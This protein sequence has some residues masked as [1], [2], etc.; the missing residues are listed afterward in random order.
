MASFGNIFGSL[1]GWLLPDRPKVKAQKIEEF[2][3]PTAEDGREFGRGYGTFWV[4]GPNVT[5]YGDLLPRTQTKNG[6][7]MIRYYMGLHIDWAEGPWDA[8]LE[9]R[10]NDP[11]GK[12]IWSGSVTSSQQITLT[13]DKL[14][15][16]RQKGGGVAGPLDVMMGED[17]QIANDYL[18]GLLGPL[19]AF[20]GVVGT[21]FRRGL[22]GANAASVT[23]WVAKGRRI[24]KGWYNDDCWYPERADAFDPFNLSNVYQDLADTL[25][26]DYRWILDSGFITISDTEPNV[27]VAGTMLLTA[28]FGSGTTSAGPPQLV[29]NCDVHIDSLI[30]SSGKTRVLTAPIS[31]NGTA[32]FSMGLWFR[33]SALTG[34]GRLFSSNH[35][36]SSIGDR[37]R[38]VNVSYQSTGAIWIMFGDGSGNEDYLATYYYATDTGVV[39]Y[40]TITQVVLTCGVGS[41]PATI[42]VHLYVNG[43]EKTLTPIIT[44]AVS[45]G[46]LVS[47]DYGIA[48]NAWYQVELGNGYIDAEAQAFFTFGQLTSGNVADLYEAGAAIIGVPMNDMNPAHILYDL[49]THPYAG[50][51]WPAAQMDDANYRA[52]ADA[53]YNEGFGLSFPPAAA[54]RRRERIAEIEEHV[55]CVCRMSSTGKFQVVLIRYDYNPD[56]LITWTDANIKAIEDVESVGYGELVGRIA[57]SYTD[58]DTGITATTAFVTNPTTIRAQAGIANPIVISYPGIRNADLAARVRDRELRKRSQPLKAFTVLLDRSDVTVE[59]GDVRKINST[60]YGYSGVIVRVIAVNRGRLT[61]RMMQIKV[62]EDVGGLPDSAYTTPVVSTWVE[63]ETAPIAIV[64]QDALEIPYHWMRAA[65]GDAEALSV[66]DTEGFGRPLAVT[67]QALAIGYDLWGRISPADYV[68][69]ADDLEFFD[70]ATLSA[71]IARNDTTLNITGANIDEDVVGPGHL[72]IVGDATTGEWMRITGGDLS[73]TITVDR[74]ILDTTPQEHD[75]GARVWVMHPEFNIFDE[76]RYVDADVVDYKMLTL[77]NEDALAI[78]DATAVSVTMDSRQ[79]RPYP[80]AGMTINGEGYPTSLYG[81]LSVA[82][83]DRNRLTQYPDIYGQSEATVTPEAGTTINGYAYDDD[84]D[85]VLV[86]TAGIGNPWA[87]VI[88]GSRNLRIEIESERGGIVSWQRQVRVFTYT[89]TAPLLDEDDLEI[90]DEDD[91]PITGE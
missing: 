81:S 20:K 53:L 23:P 77:T 69:V 78:G 88:V 41:N 64:I 71:A 18:T 38:G 2:T 37:A 57:V 30:M 68:S 32:A 31:V 7:K 76:T 15:G 86:S 42:D 60:R 16:G 66:G 8:F 44:A 29:Q 56:S 9:L 35:G 12:L 85:A 10:V 74:A 40:N 43:V 39:N 82:Y 75:V 25:S 34:G 70:S 90:L 27:G 26:I 6:E 49:H 14:F 87:P 13:K 59:R 54:S 84:T 4:L 73:A 47:G 61:D 79:I 72:L 17:T 91:I 5:W 58:P 48:F 19:P 46:W 62:V 11:Q 55:D 21:V 28:E 50:M 33:L 83:V 67:P 51:G 45:I 52:I 63:P 1:F 65:L 24:F 80:P 3:L 89:S 22:V 36:N